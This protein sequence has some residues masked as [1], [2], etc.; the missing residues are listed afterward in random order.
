MFVCAARKVMT[1]QMPRY[2]KFWVC[3]LRLPKSQWERAKVSDC[4]CQGSSGSLR[5]AGT[6]VNSVYS[7]FMS[8]CATG[9]NP[10]AHWRIRSGLEAL[11]TFRDYRVE[12]LSRVSNRP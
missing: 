3:R 9:G 5:R 11:G 4:D 12:S 6:I 7:D 1:H 10:A 2:P 8:K